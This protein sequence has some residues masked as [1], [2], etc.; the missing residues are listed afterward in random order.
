[1]L[2]WGLVFWLIATKGVDYYRLAQDE[3]A[4]RAQFNAEYR[5]IRPGDT[6]EILDPVATVIS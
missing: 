6:R 4:L 2:L 5:Q 1:M 3:A